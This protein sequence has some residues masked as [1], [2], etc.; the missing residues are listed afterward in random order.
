[1]K[2][3]CT[4][5][6][7]DLHLKKENQGVFALWQRFLRE[8]VKSNNIE[9]IYLLGDFFALW[10]GDDDVSPFTL[11]VA[12]V[13]RNITQQG[14]KVYLLPGNRD[15]MLG[16]QFATLSNCTLIAD[17][18]PIDLYHIPTVLT[19]GDILC[20][21]DVAMNIFRAITRF[22]LSKKLFL[23]LPLEIRRKIAEWIH[24]ISNHS[25]KNTGKDD[26]I[27]K[28]NAHK[29]T[30][31]TVRKLLHKYHAQQLIHG[32]MHYAGVFP[33][34]PITT[35]TIA[36][37]AAIT[38]VIAEADA[39]AN[40]HH[41]LQQPMRRFMLGEWTKYQGSVLFYY[42]NG[43]FELK[44]FQVPNRTPTKKTYKPSAKLTA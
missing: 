22:K 20:T 10:A 38:S 32:H 11:K 23:L 27:K 7:A 12:A 43:E 2:P 18:T 35:N 6:I 37:T 31:R 14:I 29:V 44:D 40:N 9:A 15:F 30:E 3:K 1:M 13:I 42:E 24:A 17:P 34:A 8:Q 4:V 21:D 19:H 33:V 28:Q 26:S 39:T 25:R 5:F 41:K 16:K 36:N